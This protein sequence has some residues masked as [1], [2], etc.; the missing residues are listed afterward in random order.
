MSV[1]R[2]RIT[3]ITA[4]LFAA[5]CCAACGV[6]AEQINAT[7]Q[8]ERNATH[9]SQ[10]RA[11]ATVQR[12]R[13]SITLDYAGTRVKQAADAGAFLR[14]NLLALGTDS[15][16]VDAALRRIERLA[17]TPAPSTALPERAD[18]ATS[19]ADAVAIDRE[20]IAAIVTP[21]PSPP[22]G[23]RVTEAVLASG[24]DRDDC[25]TDINPVFTPASERIYVVATAHKIP[26]GGSL[27]SLWQFRS[28]P[29]AN[30]SFRADRA[31]D[32]SCIWFYID[33]TDAPF[34]PGPWSVELRLDGEALAPPLPFQ[35]APG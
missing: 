26:A 32:G 3:A 28:A 2:H 33:E 27:S 23:P 8:Y 17:D 9:I 15:A 18:A 24:I 7:A 19:A 16:F 14:S 5:L 4:L 34:T 12:A 10:V 22:A 6:S 30:I 29:V 11:S 21:P 35:I 13:L 25:A 31:I 20:S 1:P